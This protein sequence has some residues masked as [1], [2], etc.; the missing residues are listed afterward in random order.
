MAI[1]DNDGDEYHVPGKPYI[2]RNKLGVLFCYGDISFTKQKV[3]P[4]MRTCK[5]LKALRGDA[6]EAFRLSNGG[7]MPPGGFGASPVAAP[8]APVVL[9]GFDVTGSIPTRPGSFAAGLDAMLGG[10][11]F[12]SAAADILSKIP[13]VAL[14]NTNGE[15]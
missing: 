8:T 2:I 3:P 11:N 15:D 4:H 5:H 7:L 9:A 12:E 13:G 1:L 14:T 10:T 6:A